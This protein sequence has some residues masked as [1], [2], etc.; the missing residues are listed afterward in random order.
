M[1]DF[2]TDSGGDT[3]SQKYE[4]YVKDRY[5]T[6]DIIDQLELNYLSAFGFDPSKSDM[7]SAL[8]FVSLFLAEVGETCG[9]T[10]V[11]HIATELIGLVDWENPIKTA[12][13]IGQNIK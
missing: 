8:N 9:G 11:G 2:K 10:R 12:E 4:V 13:N 1:G 3:F 5:T 6:G 7:Q